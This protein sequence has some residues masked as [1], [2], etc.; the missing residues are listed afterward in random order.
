MSFD[1]EPFVMAAERATGNLRH[2][3]SVMSLAPVI[4]AAAPVRPLSVQGRRGEG[5]EE[6]S[7]RADRGARV[8]APA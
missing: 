7:L 2:D 1:V 4:D 8:Q 6:A 5:W 3:A